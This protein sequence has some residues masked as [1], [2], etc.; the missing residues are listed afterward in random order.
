MDA[1]HKLAEE[2]LEVLLVAEFLHA[3]ESQLI[4]EDEL[5]DEFLRH[6]LH[7][8]GVVEVLGV[9]DLGRGDG[10]HYGLSRFGLLLSARHLLGRLFVI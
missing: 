3:V 10:A 2:R 4:E 8:V 7:F 5:I 1:F 6:N 9:L